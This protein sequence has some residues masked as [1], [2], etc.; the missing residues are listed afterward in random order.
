[1]SPVK[2]LV[3]GH[4]STLPA[5]AVVA[6]NES[7]AVGFVN[8][9][10]PELKE[11]AVLFVDSEQA[12]ANMIDQARNVRKAIAEAKEHNQRI[13]FFSSVRNPVYHTEL[14]VVIEVCQENADGTL[15]DLGQM[16]FGVRFVKYRGYK[17]NDQEILYL[18]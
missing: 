6:D 2:Q 18:C 12:P 16:A 14:P 13:V 1:M 4:F 5:F 17:P 8:K 3:L 9:L 10:L 15:F 11:D 7:D